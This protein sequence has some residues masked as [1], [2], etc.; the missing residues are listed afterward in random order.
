M[1]HR[2]VD[3]GSR[4]AQVNRQPLRFTNGAQGIDAR[5]PIWI[6]CD[7]A[8]PLS[9]QRLAQHFKVEPPPAM[10][11]F[12]AQISVFLQV[13][14]KETAPGGRFTLFC[15]GWPSLRSR[16]AHWGYPHTA[17]EGH[18]QSFTARLPEERVSAVAPPN[19]SSTRGT[20]HS[21]T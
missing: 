13:F 16:I 8:I 2:P 18:G 20:S 11:P 7:P 17:S 12:N 5:V 15:W 10:V 6:A 9:A 3:G 4:L 14:D 21:L 1:A 19:T